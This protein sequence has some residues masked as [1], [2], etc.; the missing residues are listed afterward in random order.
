M[1]RRASALT[2]RST[3]GVPPP[4][5]DLGAVHYMT[6]AEMRDLTHGRS[7]SRAQM[8]LIAGRVSALRECFY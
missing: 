4:G 3:G 5:Q 7:L 2:W 8:E 1:R 6:T